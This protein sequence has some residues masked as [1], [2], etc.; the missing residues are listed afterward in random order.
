MRFKCKNAILSAKTFFHREVAALGEERALK[1]YVKDLPAW[2]TFPDVERVE[3]LN[4]IIA[5]F[6]PHIGSFADRML[7]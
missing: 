5:T 2:I 1:K 4:H 3:W 6:W 7:R